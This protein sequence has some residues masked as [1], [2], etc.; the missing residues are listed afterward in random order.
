M[1]TRALDRV[2]AFTDAAVAIGLT[3]LVL[4]LV[5]LAHGGEEGPIR[6]LL[7]EHT[8][9]L[10]AFLLSFFVIMA[11]WRGHRRLYERLGRVDET[12]LSLNTLWLLGIVFLPVPTAVLTF[13]GDSQRAAALLY[14]MNLLFVA[15]MNAGMVGWIALHPGLLD[16]QHAGRPMRHHVRRG[17]ILC[18]MIGVVTLLAIPL[19]PTALILLAALPI[20][21]VIGERL[22][23]RLGRDLPG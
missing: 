16:P 8:D 11:F 12:L 17:L 18:G 21:Q 3:L 15:L 7:R 14:L 13:E 10:I 22:D 9:D 2:T 19:G 23:R 20:G 1:D 6:A 5:D 4:P